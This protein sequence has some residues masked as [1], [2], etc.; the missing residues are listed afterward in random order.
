MNLYRVT[1]ARPF[2]IDAAYVVARDWSEAA[3]KGAALDLRNTEACEN[4]G[5]SSVE[6]IGPAADVL[7][8]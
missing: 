1:I 8:T 3:S 5:V 6:Y 2:A 7:A 4:G